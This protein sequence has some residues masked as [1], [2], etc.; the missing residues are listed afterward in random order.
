MSSI[1][2]GNSRS[3]PA[4]SPLR[5]S[6]VPRG[7]QNNSLSESFAGEK[8]WKSKYPRLTLE[9]PGIFSIIFQ[10]YFLQFCLPTHVGTQHLGNA[11]AAVSTQIIFQKRDK[12]AG[13]SHTGIVQR[14][15]QYNRR[16]FYLNKE[17][18]YKLTK[19]VAVLQYC[20]IRISNYVSSTDSKTTKK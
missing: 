12:H 5:L 18:V 19:L 2:H 20:N 11:H 1:F 8:A 13:R 9:K 10:L 7:K 3:I 6:S 15:R 17:I 4:F 16:I 14:M